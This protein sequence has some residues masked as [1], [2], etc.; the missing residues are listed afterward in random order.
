[1]PLIRLYTQK[2]NP[3]A[4]KVARALY[5][6][7]LEHERIVSE[8]P[9]DIARWNPVTKQ[10]PVLEVDDE[11][12]SDSGVIL[13]RIEEL[14]PEPPL[15]SPD[16]VTAGAQRRMADWSDV[17][18]VWYWNRWRAARFPQ[19]GDE[20]PADRSLIRKFKSGVLRSLGLD[21]NQLTRLEVREAEIGQ[22][23]SNRLDDLVV[24]LGGREFFHSDQ[25]SVADLSVFGMLQVMRDSPMMGDGSQLDARPALVA[26]M[27][28]VEALTRRPRAD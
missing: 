27:E 10:L 19:P 9:D 25:L 21:S 6:K 23:L 20:Q 7:G 11:R 15:L 28:R 5:F 8:D 14:F 18:F 13:E 16:P 1:M 22:E 2:V 3:Y 4:E 26:Y 12:V 24:M 17:S